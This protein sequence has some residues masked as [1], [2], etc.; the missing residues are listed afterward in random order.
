M[1]SGCITPRVDDDNPVEGV[2]GPDAGGTHRAKAGLTMR[3]PGPGLP[4]AAA[5]RHGEPGSDGSPSLATQGSRPRPLIEPLLTP[6][7]VPVE[8]DA[9]APYRL[10]IGDPVVIVMRGTL[11]EI[12]DFIDE[13]GCITLPYIDK[14]KAVGMTGAELEAKI[15][16]IYVPDY[17][18]FMTVNVVVATRRSYFMRGEI[19]RPGQVPYVGGT[20]LL[21]AVASAGGFTGFANA[22]KITITRGSQITTHNFLEIE[23]NPDR[24][25]AIEAGDIIYVP[26]GIL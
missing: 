26:R 24:D 2:A 11:G 1:V 17:Y 23:K 7:S 8:V 4:V 12:P 6:P 10:K 22:K 14:V 25:I 3:G 18:K 15:Q 21:E 16:E 19:R 9:G 13:T 5:S 20:T